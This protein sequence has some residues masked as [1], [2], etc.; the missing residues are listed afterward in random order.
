MRRRDRCAGWSCCGTPSPPGHECPPVTSARRP[1]AAAGTPPPV[2]LGPRLHHADVPG[3]PDVIREAPAEVETLPLVGRHPGP[4][5]LVPALAPDGLDD[6]S[7][8]VRVTFPPP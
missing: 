8:R 7:D 1:P 4:E 2:R 3:L 5:D 6:T